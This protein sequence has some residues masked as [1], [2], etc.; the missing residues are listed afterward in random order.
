MH[1]AHTG[2]SQAL[3]PVD[4]DILHNSI[5]NKKPGFMVYQLMA[6]F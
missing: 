6:N 5:N 1:G 3:E 2:A 4:S